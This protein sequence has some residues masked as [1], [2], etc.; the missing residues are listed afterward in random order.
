[1]I[2][3]I[4]NKYRQNIKNNELKINGYKKKLAFFSI[5][6]FLCFVLSF[7]MLF[8]LL[9]VNQS[10]AIILCVVLFSIFIVLVIRYIKIRY[11][12]DICQSLVNINKLEIKALDHDFSFLEN[13]KK[14]LNPKHYYSHDLD[15]FGNNS[16]FQY[17]NRTSTNLGK[18]ILAEWFIKPPLEDID[19]KNRQV[20]IQELSSKLSW[21]QLFQAH[22]NQFKEGE[23]DEI[24]I[25]DWIT[26][27]SYFSKKILYQV[28]RF[29]FPITTC[30]L[31]VFML[32]GLVSFS[33]FTIV[34]IGQ[35]IFSY[36][37]LKKMDQINEQVAKKLETLKKYSY[38]LKL[39]ENENFQ[40]EI[41]AKLQKQLW[42]DEINSNQ[43]LLKLS[44]LLN[45]LESKNNLVAGILINGFFSWNIH[46]LFA[47]EKWKEKYREHVNDWF[48]SIKHI[49]A[50]NSL[51]NYSYNNPGFCLPE[52][53]YSSVISSKQLG[54]PLIHRDKRVCN[55][56]DIKNSGEFVV[57]TGPN[58]AGKSTF[59]RTV[60]VNMILARLGAPV[61]ASKLSFKPRQIYTSMRTTDSLLDNESYFLAELRRF[62]YLFDIVK[63]DKNIFIILDEILKGTNIQDKQNGSKI[64]LEKLIMEGI[65][66]IIATHDLTISDLKHKYP[67]NIFDKSFEIEIDNDKIIYSYLLREGISNKMNAMILMKQLGITT[68]KE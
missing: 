4:K 22:G 25:S 62:K 35:L 12:K 65:P 10:L 48:E 45:G 28:L 16:V 43:A 59:L 50:L 9:K 54:H 24:V 31:F 15:I 33:L 63:N 56:L 41:L 14:Y 11:K 1:M 42:L 21:R 53:D 64:I 37:E 38:L 30:G 3:E 18:D 34:F 32:V 6:R 44:K 17:I 58:M 39:I 7:L 36:F 8:A 49:D 68:I 61:C 2:T 19:I 52:I 20:A 26:E 5:L 60:G 29:I 13:G 46:F 55:D 66:G 40:S 57:I 23:N 67:D 51:A 47:I 27:P